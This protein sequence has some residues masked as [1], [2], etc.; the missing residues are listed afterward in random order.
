[1]SIA[2]T[3]SE[4][5]F[6]NLPQDRFLA[7]RAR[8]LEARGRLKSIEKLIH[9]SFDSAALR[10][11]LE[12]RLDGDFEILMV[13]SSVNR[14]KPMYTDG[15]LDLVRMLIDFC[16]STRTLAMPAFFFGDPRIGTVQETFTKNPRLDLRKTPSQMGIA[17]ELF[18][19]SKGVLQSR[20]PVYRVSAL[21]PLAEELTAGHESAPVPAGLGSPFEFM[22]KR[23]TLVIGIGKSFDVMTQVH[24][25]EG[26]MGGDFPVPMTP[27]EERSA[28]DITVIDG[29]ED[30]PVT[31]RGSSILWRFNI[32]K[33]PS[34][35]DNGQL[36][37]WKFHS[38]P[39]FAADAG[40]VTRTLIDAAK[41]GKTLYDEL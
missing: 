19:R 18:R 15:P 21:G 36:K 40:D 4:I 3:L 39:L 5:A 27:F 2:S 29:G 7:L 1:M 6:R 14:L 8:Y 31:L 30:V 16:G 10:S 38:V 24:H 12:Q 41:R 17:T 13:H 26:A 9:G 20:H 34:L 37:C 35:L 33:L 28:L 22:A 23:K 25:V 11:H 32:S